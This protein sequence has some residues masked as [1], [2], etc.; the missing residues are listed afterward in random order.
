M[1][2]IA[3]IGFMG[4]GKSTVASILAKKTHRTLVETDGEILSV[5]GLPSI[6]AIFDEKGESYFRKL[7]QNVIAEI[8]KRNNQV[9]SCGGGVV[10][11]KESMELL[12]K[13]AKVIFLHAS[14][15]A[16]KTRLRDSDSRPLFRQEEK[17]MLLYANR[18]PIYE[19]FADYIIETDN[20]SP[21]QIAEL[22]IEV[23]PNEH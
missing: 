23:Y 4:A 9:I 5:A 1:K 12:K 16:I 13:H 17:A 20:K 10:S 7:E 11:S 22:I 6:N 3:L 14:F 19:S 15:E 21:E 2:N 8:V 18:L